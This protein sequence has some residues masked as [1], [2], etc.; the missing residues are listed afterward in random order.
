VFT[1]ATR[2]GAALAALSVLSLT[3]GACGSESL[4]TG[5]TTTSNAPSATAAVPTAAK[6]DALAAKVP[7]KIRTAGKLVDG[8]DGTYAP[9]EFVGD[10]GKTLEGM[11]ID[12]L[13]AVA[14]TLGLTVEYNNAGF[15]TILLGVTSGKY[16]VAISSFTIN[17]ERKKQVNM[18]QYFNA[19]TSW[20]VAKGNPK[21][22]D[23]NNV[24]GLTIAVQKGTV[25]VDDLNKRSKEC[26]DAG[27]DAI[28]QVVEGSQAKATANLVSGKADAMLA[29]SPITAYAIQQSNDALEGVGEMYDAAPYGI[30][31]PKDQTE[32]ADAISGALAK[33][34]QDGVYDAILTKWGTQD[35]AVTDF[36]VN[37]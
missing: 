28:K 14:T 29:D 33:L 9:N 24:C 2:T 27:K 6:D 22:V 10:D 17:D 26:T 15:D 12:L 13:N 20:A 23:L 7:E 31:V 30:V 35:G 25:Q 37:P 21:K 18:V 16:D 19:G 5:G 1:R 4:D 32:M 3:L 11:D 36:P 8:T 34:K